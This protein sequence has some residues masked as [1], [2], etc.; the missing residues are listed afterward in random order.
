M[1]SYCLW[2]HTGGINVPGHLNGEVALQMDYGDLNVN[3]VILLLIVF[4]KSIQL[5][6]LSSVVGYSI[7]LKGHS[8]GIRPQVLNWGWFHHLSSRLDFLD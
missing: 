1:Q 5:M 3:R 7:H 4:S 8:R 2:V 6:C